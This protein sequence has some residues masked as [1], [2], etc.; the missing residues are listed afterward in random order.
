MIEKQKEKMEFPKNG[1]KV[2]F[3]TPAKF[4]FH[5]NVVQDQDLLEIGKEYTVR[6]TQV[7]S[8]SSYVWLEEIEV[9]NEEHDKPYFNLWSFDW[10]GSPERFR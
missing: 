10:E 8:S 6:R 2:T 1:T 3:T 9:Y 7:N 5:N 4:A